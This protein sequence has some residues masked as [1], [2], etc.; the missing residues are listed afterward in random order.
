VGVAA[1]DRS[2]EKSGIGHDRV[3]PVEFWRERRKNIGHRYAREH[4]FAVALAEPSRLRR[5][6]EIGLILS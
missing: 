3:R 6:L 2:G 5:K 1:G 4:D